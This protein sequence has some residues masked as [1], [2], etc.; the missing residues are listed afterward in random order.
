MPHIN[1]F[2][3][4]GSVRSCCIETMAAF[5]SCFSF[6][7]WWGK[8]QSATYHNLSHLPPYIIRAM[9]AF[10]FGMKKYLKNDFIHVISIL[11]EKVQQWV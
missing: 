2:S 11:A 6:L 8:T 9:R 10:P 7:S 4:S 1:V 3:H 5:N